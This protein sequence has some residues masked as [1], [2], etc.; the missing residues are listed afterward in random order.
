MGRY[1]KQI[2]NILQD[3]KEYIELDKVGTY[4]VDTLSERMETV[5]NNQYLDKMDATACSRWEKILGIDN[6]KLPLET[7]ILI[8]KEKINNNIPYTIY[9]LKNTLKAIMGDTKF[10]VDM[11]YDEYTLKVNLEFADKT[12]LIST[13][14]YIDLVVPCNIVV[15][16]KN[17]K[18]YDIRS[19][20]KIVGAI[21]K[22]N[23]Y[24]IKGE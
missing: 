17:N 9:T 5:N 6:S 15:E 13:K 11:L 3:V 2:P 10:D 24:T 21:T 20:T 23:I 18:N 4:G 19:E 12:M 22:T 16:I 1:L 7:R 14:A 8:I